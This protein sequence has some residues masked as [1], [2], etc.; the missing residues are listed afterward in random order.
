MT[1]RNYF[2]S[3]LFVTTICIGLITA[4][5]SG[6][7][8]STGDNDKVATPCGPEQAL[9]EYSAVWTYYNCGPFNQLFIYPQQVDMNGV[10][11]NST[12]VGKGM[13]SLR[14]TGLSIES[15]RLRDSAPTFGL[16][17]QAYGNNNDEVNWAWFSTRVTTDALIS[18]LRSQRFDG[19]CPGRDLCESPEQ[20]GKVQ[21][22]NPAE[23]YQW[24]CWW[25]DTDSLLGTVRC[26]VTQMSDDRQLVTLTV[27]TYGLYNGLN[28]MG[29]GNPSF[30]G[31][32]PGYE[33][34]VSD[35][36]ITIF[37]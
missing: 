22:T 15:F 3:S 36:K 35:L 12:P 10:A 5:S 14:Y 8:G 30:D 13:I 34:T 28:Y 32:Y 11:L 33:G 17:F 1:S 2:F 37:Q 29:F 18:T 25:D 7:G 16:Y 20:T 24:D 6:G 4:C 27:K 21:F 9:K 23:V 31:P 19:S 26:T